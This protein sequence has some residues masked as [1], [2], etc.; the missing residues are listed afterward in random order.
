MKLEKLELVR[1][2]LDSAEGSLRSAKQLLLEI[3]GAKPDLYKDKARDLSILEGGK[4]IEGIFDGENMVAPNDKKYPV[5]PNYASKS[6]L[7]PGDVLKLTI[8]PDGSFIFKQIGPVERKKIVGTL[9]QDNDKYRVLADGKAYNVLYASV[10]YFKAN[11]GD[12]VT[13]IVPEKE[14]SVWGAI[15]NVIGAEGGQVEAEPEKKKEEKKK[16]KIKEE[17]VRK[18]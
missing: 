9:A 8:I 15:E 13:L 10:T 6:K 18:K 11:P 12:K 14:E 1:Q 2:L 16:K 4:V 7:V 17:K 3:A 5:P